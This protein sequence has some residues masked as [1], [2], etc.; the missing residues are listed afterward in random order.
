MAEA[1]A[2]RFGRYQVVATLGRGAM[3][4]VYAAVDDVLGREVAIKTLRGTD[5]GMAPRLLDARFRHEA[6]AIAQLAHPGVVQV[7]DI[8]VTATPPYL[9]MERVEGPSLAT[10]LDAGPLSPSEVRAMGI[11]IGRALSAAHQRGV[12][13]RDVK[14]G[15]ILAAGS[16]RWKLADF[17][18]AHV[19]DSSLTLTGQFI[20]SPAYA[21]PEALTRGELGPP[22]DVYGLAASLYQAASGRW[23]RA[24]PTTAGVRGLLAPPPPLT[25]LA[26]GFP[27]ELAQVIER[28]LDIEPGN[29]PTADEL[30]RAMAGDTSVAAATPP[31]GA[32]T[33][34]LRASSPVSFAPEAFAATTASPIVTPA[35]PAAVS[36]AGHVVATVPVGTLVQPTVPAATQIVS[37]RKQWKRYLPWAAV[38]V[39]LI[40]GIVIGVMHAGGGSETKPIGSG[41]ASGTGLPSFAAD[42]GLGTPEFLPD[43][44]DDGTIMAHQPSN[45]DAQNARDW[46]KAVEKLYDGDL[47]GARKKLDEF[48]RKH[49]RTPESS[50]LAAQLDRAIQRTGG[51]LDDNESG[52]GRGRFKNK[53]KKDD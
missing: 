44:P 35:S 5:N 21:A 20:G 22:G 13:H 34:N 45:L 37:L 47:A 4:E 27:P 43:T 42:D 33:M 9:V 52:R 19:P 8:D 38:A 29:R 14:P 3:G 18:V 36:T 26:P 53:G 46:E 2:R 25:E 40:G 30:A 39:A 7:F 49:G 11:Q 6:R 41:V 32:P 31:L 10:R 15:N 51:S 28:A 16:G 23:P 50:D 48:E 17:G 24:E 12:V 1:Q